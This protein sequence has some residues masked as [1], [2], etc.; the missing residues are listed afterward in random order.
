MLSVLTLQLA[1]PEA[2]GRAASALQLGDALACST[3]LA[4][5]GVLFNAAGSAGRPA[6]LAVLGLCAGLALLGAALAPRAFAGPL[7]P[8]RSGLGAVDDLGRRA[9][10]LHRGG[11]PQ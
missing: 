9:E 6:F 2:Q 3:T 10:A 1:A 5:A 7:S 8:R 11:T 4:L